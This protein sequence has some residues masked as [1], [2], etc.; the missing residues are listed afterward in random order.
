[1]TRGKKEK[2]KKK[3]RKKEERSLFMVGKK[4]RARWIVD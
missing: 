3:S 2:K 4:V 1:M